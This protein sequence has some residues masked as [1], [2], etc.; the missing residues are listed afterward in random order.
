MKLTT[1]AVNLLITAT[2][3][4]IVAVLCFLF[5]LCT[6]LF[7]GLT[8]TTVTVCTVVAIAAGAL[9]YY[10]FEEVVLEH[11]CKLY[12]YYLQPTSR[13][14]EILAGAACG[15]ATFPV[16]AMFT[17]VFVALGMSATVASPVSFAISMLMFYMNIGYVTLVTKRLAA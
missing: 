7:G 2:V 6:A 8:A 9:V 17:Y 11:V 16:P 14:K 3:V 4:M 5:G 10:A 12:T 15:L 1:I 13:V